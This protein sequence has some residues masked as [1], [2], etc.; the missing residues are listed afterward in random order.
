MT[1]MP[2]LRGRFTIKTMAGRAV[3]AA[4]V[5]EC[6][7]QEHAIELA[8]VHLL[9]AAPGVSVEVWARQSLLWSSLTDAKAGS[10]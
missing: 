9:K 6:A 1:A 3:L 7:D 10:V 5:L 2:D 8:R 4:E